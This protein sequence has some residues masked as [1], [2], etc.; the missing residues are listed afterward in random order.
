MPFVS[1]CVLNVSLLTAYFVV[2]IA[3]EFMVMRKLSNVATELFCVLLGLNPALCCSRF[4][5]SFTSFHL[6]SEWGGGCYTMFVGS[7]RIQ[8]NAYVQFKRAHTRVSFKHVPPQAKRG[9]LAAWAKR[10]R[11][12][13]RAAPRQSG[14]AGGALG[15]CTGPKQLGVRVGAARSSASDPRAASR[16]ASRPCAGG[17]RPRSRKT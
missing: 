15:L 12:G 4:H 2:S 10:T 14:Y 17:S 3:L 7:L 13:R 1:V 6:K 8:R 16:R 11:T 5:F 9:G